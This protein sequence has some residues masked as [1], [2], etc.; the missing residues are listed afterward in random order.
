MARALATLDGVLV[1]EKKVMGI[2]EYREGKNLSAEHRG[3]IL[4]KSPE[5]DLWIFS[6]AYNLT[7][8]AYKALG[9]DAFLINPLHAHARAYSTELMQWLNVE[10]SF[11]SKQLGHLPEPA[12]LVI[13]AQKH[14]LVPVH[15][16][17]FVL[18]RPEEVIVNRLSE[19]LPEFE[20]WVRAFAYRAQEVSGIDYPKTWGL[21]R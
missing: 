1:L 10:M 14:H 16:A 8:E 17:V 7:D 18:K 15:K 20:P 13:D 6:F 5:S 21:G 19:C 9:G 3:L 11:L 12:E 2:G 4:Q